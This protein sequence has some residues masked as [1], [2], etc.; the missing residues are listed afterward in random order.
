MRSESY[1]HGKVGL[2][3]KNQGP[4][5][6]FVPNEYETPVVHIIIE[7]NLS[8]NENRLQQVLDDTSKNKA[9]LLP[10]YFLFES[11]RAKCER[12]LRKSILDSATAVEVCFSFLINQLLAYDKEINKY[13]ASKHNS[14]R[15]KRD[16]LKVLKIDIPIK[17][18]TY[19]DNLDDIRN[20]VIHAGYSPNNH[21]AYN[22]YKIAK[23]TLYSLLPKKYEM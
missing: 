5:Q 10:F 20:K 3:K 13:V 11:E 2:F 18:K 1:G 22:A 6:M 9:P 23:E 17:E 12:N 14:L 19:K 4:N 8:F 15:L 21:E 7:D 16:L